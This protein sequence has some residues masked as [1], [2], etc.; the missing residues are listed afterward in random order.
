MATVIAP[1]ADTLGRSLA[2]AVKDAYRYV[3]FL[4]K[5]APIMYPRLVECNVCGWRGKHFLSDVWHKH[6][7]CP[8]CRSGVRHRLLVAALTYLDAFSFDAVVR[9]KRV[10]HFAPEPIMQARLKALAASYVTA[11]Y[12]NPRRDLQLD[13]SNMNVIG[14]GQFDLLIA[15]DVL[16]HVE[17]D[18]AAMREI[19]R[20]LSPNGC[21][22]LT[23]PQQD[24]LAETFEDPAIVDPLERAQVFG[25]RDHV[26]IYGNDFPQRLESAGFLVSAVNE[27][28]FPSAMNKRNVLFPPELS[29]NPLAT[30][31]RKVFFARK[32]KRRS[33]N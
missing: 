2:K 26:R 33:S 17:D 25:Q 21:A 7:N 13:I 19:F 3:R 29:Q 30:N 27:T 6:S 14:D 10:L 22:I 31:Y 12:L 5:A 8:K 1:K 4:F 20:V 15:C 28:N 9:G 18:D 32:L 11:D 16:E 23:V 24:N